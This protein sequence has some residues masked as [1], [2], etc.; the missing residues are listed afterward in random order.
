MAEARNATTLTIL[1]AELQSHAGRS[2][3]LDADGV[4]LR[5]SLT[6]PGPRAATRLLLKAGRRFLQSAANVLYPFSSPVSLFGGLACCVGLVLRSPPESWLRSG[7]VATALWDASGRLGLGWLPRTARVALLACPAGIVALSLVAGAQRTLLWLLLRDKAWLRTAREPSL[8][9]RAWF[10]GVRLLTRGPPATFSLQ[11]ALPKQPLPALRATVARYLDAAAQ[12]QAPAE[13]ERTRAAAAAFLAGEGPRLQMLLSLKRLLYAH[14]T[15]DW[16]EKYVYLKGRESIAINSNYYVLTQGRWQPTRSQAARAAVQL[17]QFARFNSKLVA[18]GVKPI[19]IQD[20]V[21]LCMWQY[22]R[23]FATTR[24]PGRECDAVRH[25]DPATIRH[26]AVM[27]KGS[28]FYLNL[29]TRGGRQRTPKQ[30]QAALEEIRAAA[31]GLAPRPAEAAIPAL[32]SENRGVW[33]E[34]RE[35][36]FGDGQN[37]RS[38]AL[39]ESALLWL[40]LEDGAPPLLDWSA[41]GKALIHGDP[42]KPSIWFDKSLSM[43]VFADGQM[44]AFPSPPPSFPA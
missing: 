36:H 31:A 9:V 40:S 27:C 32:T 35:T 24:V 37:R 26:A 28:M 33:A 8:L 44:C 22:E 20:T 23:M 15:T 6:L 3:W 42:K 11:G 17:Y 39:V 7:A 19:A 38:L 21:P 29:Y 25:W 13:L 12:L 18:D 41:R 5:I 4:H 2:I 16:W 10:L 43:L 34:A 1:K 30:L 14:P